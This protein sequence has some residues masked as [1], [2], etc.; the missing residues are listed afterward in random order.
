MFSNHCRTYLAN[1]FDITN[2]QIWIEDA[3]PKN[4]MAALA[5]LKILI[6]NKLVSYTKLFSEDTL[7][8]QELLSCFKFIFLPET[9]KHGNTLDFDIIRQE[10]VKEFYTNIHI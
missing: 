1:K 6:N 8:K 9:D 3:T 4:K 5:N 2:N 10:L 7:A